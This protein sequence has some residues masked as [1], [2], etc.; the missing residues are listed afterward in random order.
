ME[1]SVLYFYIP[2]KEI[3]SI[4]IHIVYSLK[5]FSIKMLTCQFNALCFHEQTPFMKLFNHIKNFS[6]CVNGQN[7]AGG[8]LE[9]LPWKLQYFVIPYA[10]LE[11]Q[12]PS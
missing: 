10:D 6:A 1:F 4:K 7:I 3:H 9:V 2:R 5:Y 8:S 12:A 11:A